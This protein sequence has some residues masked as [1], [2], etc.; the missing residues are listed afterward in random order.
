MKLS[1]KE[2]KRLFDT[3]LIEDPGP[4][5]YVLQRM[6]KHEWSF[7]PRARR[8]TLLLRQFHEQE[9]VIYGRWKNFTK[10]TYPNRKWCWCCLCGTGKYSHDSYDAVDHRG[11]WEI[12]VD[13]AAAMQGQQGRSSLQHATVSRKQLSIHAFREALRCFHN[14]FWRHQ[15]KLRRAFEPLAGR[16]PGKLRLH[17]NRL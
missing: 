1:R 2:A 14:F 9:Q 12:C 4:L 5:D 6:M 3:C 17:R 13:C 10:T 16:L 7:D 15:L 11:S 8:L